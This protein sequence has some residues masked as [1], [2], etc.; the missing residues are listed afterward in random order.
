MEKSSAGHAH[1]SVTAQRT[2]P[3]R[4][5]AT[6]GGGCRAM[7]PWRRRLRPFATAI[8]LKS[9]ISQMRGEAPAAATR[10]GEYLHIYH[11]SVSPFDRCEDQGIF[12]TALMCERWTEVSWNLIPALRSASHSIPR[13]KEI[14]YAEGECHAKSALRCLAIK[15][16]SID[17]NILYMLTRGLNAPSRHQ[18]AYSALRKQLNHLHRSLAVQ[19]PH[20]KTDI[21]CAASTIKVMGVCVWYWWPESGNR[22]LPGCSCSLP[23]GRL[24]VLE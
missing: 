21:Y 15:R 2:C 18:R 3:G 13:A 14:P 6:D 8:T 20:P 5:G 7:E 4:T 16:R 1:C 22:Q 9:R 12:C 11:C 19:V 10:T 24:Q 17:R 23:C